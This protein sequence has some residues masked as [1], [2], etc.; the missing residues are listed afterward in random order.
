MSYVNSYETCCC[1]FCATFGCNCHITGRWFFALC[2][3]LQCRATA[4]KI[5]E[6]CSLVLS[7]T[8]IGFLSSVIVIVIVCYMVRLGLLHEECRRID[9]AQKNCQ[10]SKTVR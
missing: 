5:N 4:A 7:M 10:N 2:I 8:P 3:G 6:L 1:S 9:R